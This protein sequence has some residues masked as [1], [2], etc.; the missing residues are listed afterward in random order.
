MGGVSGAVLRQDCQKGGACFSLKL[1]IFVIKY[2]ILLKGV[3]KIF[4]HG[5]KM[6]MRLSQHTLLWS[7]HLSLAPFGRSGEISVTTAT[8]AE[9]TSSHFES[10]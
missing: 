10:M 1:T 8:S 9:I 5:F 3:R 6:R 4:S 7:F 2:T